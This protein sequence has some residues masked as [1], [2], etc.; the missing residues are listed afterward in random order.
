MKHMINYIQTPRVSN[1]TTRI[2]SV[3][4]QRMKEFML[5]RR[6]NRWLKFGE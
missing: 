2:D 4:E 1:T 6:R 3:L 5:S